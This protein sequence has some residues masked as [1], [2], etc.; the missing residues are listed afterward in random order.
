MVYYFLAYFNARKQL[1]KTDP[2]ATIQFIVPT[3]NFGDILA[4]WYTKCMGLPLERLVVATNSND[5]LARFWSSGR[6]EK[7]QVSTSTVTAVVLETL[8]PAM[9][10][11]ISSNFERLL[12]YLAFDSLASSLSNNDVERRRVACATVK[13]WMDNVKADGRAVVSEEVLALARNDFVADRVDDEQTIETIQAY[14]KA[15]G[16]FSD[17][18]YIADPHTAVGLAVARRLAANNPPSVHQI[19]VS[20]AHPAK[21]SEAVTR[22]LVPL[23]SSFDFEREVMPEEFKGLLQ[24]E[25][26]VIDVE[27]P[28]V[29]LVKDAIIRALVAS[30]KVHPGASVNGK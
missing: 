19:V 1:E 22:A 4:A 11:L 8:S 15:E 25:R 24:K 9:D 29:E 12:W 13:G 26:R 18:S 21:F 17:G 7:H 27:R 16:G 14:Y 20:T 10:I 30:G 3:G 2:E 6:Y 23:S 5:I 28:E